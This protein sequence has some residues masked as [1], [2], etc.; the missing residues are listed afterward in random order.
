MFRVRYKGGF[1]LEAGRR[2][3]KAV[4]VSVSGK[5][6]EPSR[7]VSRSYEVIYDHESDDEDDLRVYQKK[8]T[9]QHKTAIEETEVLPSVSNFR[10]RRIEEQRK[11]DRELLVSIRTEKSLEEGRCT[12]CDAVTLSRNGSKSYI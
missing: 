12:I 4:T 2:V 8:R 3:I 11:R 10:T 1:H 7:I 6:A 5:T 9:P